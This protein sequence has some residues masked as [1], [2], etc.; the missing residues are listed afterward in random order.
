MDS[1]AQSQVSRKKRSSRLRLIGLLTALGVVAAVY[2]P[3]RAGRANDHLKK[4]LWNSDSEGVRNALDNGADPDLALSLI[5]PPD[6]VGNLADFVRLFVHR[7]ERSR[8]NDVKTALMYAAAN[9]DTE[10]VAALLTHGANVNRRLENGTTALLC[11]A[12]KADS[13]IVATLLAK[14]AD[15]HV[16]MK[17]GATPLLLAAR[18]GQLQNVR[19]LLGK[20]ENIHETDHQAQTALSLATEN[21]HEEMIQLILSQGADER[22]L[23]AARSS[24]I[25]LSV[26]SALAG[27]RVSN[28]GAFFPANGTS[29]FYPARAARPTPSLP[30]PTISPLV[31][32]AKYGSLSL[33]QFLWAHNASH[34]SPEARW[35][36]VCSA[37]IAGRPGPVRFLLDQTLPVNPPS[38]LGSSGVPGSV[39]FPQGADSDKLYTPLHYAAALDKP[40]IAVILLAHGANVNAEDAFGTTPLL[41]AVSGEHL[42][43]IRLLLAHGANVRAAERKTGQNAL[44]RGVRKVEIARLLLDHGLDVN[45]RDNAGRTALMNSFSPPVVALLIARGA[46]LALQDKQ[47][48]SPLLAAVRADRTECVALLLKHGAQVDVRNTLGETPLSVA[49]AMRFGQG[50]AISAL[51][52]AAGA[53]H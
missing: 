38:I 5:L 14:G 15:V 40:D 7:T 41:A 35:N 53:K 46:N 3:I 21:R 37:V 10:V 50:R 13:E 42:D 16:Q 2:A 47:G 52:T 45:A 6:H 4:S 33:V 36:L 24:P 51:L 27:R 17:D 26:T 29:G 32:A 34:V 49:T 8:R 43:T 9:S 48:D 25:P 23:K 18:M 19:L 22:D 28:Q 1:S 31:F 11:A 30:P 44:M 12:P 20:G 39:H